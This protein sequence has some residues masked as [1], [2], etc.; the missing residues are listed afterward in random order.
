MAMTMHP[1]LASLR[2]RGLWVFEALQAG[3]RQHYKLA[4]VNTIGPKIPLPHHWCH[5]NRSLSLAGKRACLQN[6]FSIS[7]LNTGISPGFRL[8]SMSP[9]TRACFSNPRSHS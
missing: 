1:D 3:Y 7:Q 6:S 2:L 9:S 5:W 8:V 4:I